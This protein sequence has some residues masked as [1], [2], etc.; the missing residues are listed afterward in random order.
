MAAGSWFVR[1]ITLMLWRARAAP[2][3]PRSEPPRPAKQ[4]DA[5]VL[6]VL[7][8][9][10]VLQQLGL[11]AQLL[12]ALLEHAHHALGRGRRACNA[13]KER[14]LQPREGGRECRPV[15]PSSR[16]V[17][18]SPP[19]PPARL[20]TAAPASLAA[21]ARAPSPRATPPPPPPRPPP[22]GAGAAVRWRGGPCPG[23]GGI[24]AARE[25]TSAG[26]VCIAAR[27]FCT[28][29][30]SRPRSS[31]SSASSLCASASWLTYRSSIAAIAASL[32]RSTSATY[33]AR[34]FS[35]CICISR[36][37][38]PRSRATAP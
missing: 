10:D 36:I 13:L 16:L 4:R 22:A 31:R 15:P 8:P 34:H 17:A 6:E 35:V 18:P 28:C 32:R 25:C 23:T 7:P 33:S 21:A 3:Q 14:Q 20:P 2:R 37:C 1:C 12:V 24:Q 26:R 9:R 27:T 19:H 11:L 5:P 38:D 29:V 30:A